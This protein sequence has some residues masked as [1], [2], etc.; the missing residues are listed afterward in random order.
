M[1]KVTTIESVRQALGQLEGIE[2]PD[3]DNEGDPIN[4]ESVYDYLDEDDQVKVDHALTTVRDYILDNGGDIDN[5]R[6]SEIKRNGYTI[7]MGPSQY[8]PMRNA[9][10]VEAGEWTLDLSDREPS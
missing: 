9:G 3:M 8:D 2:R 1:L 5:R 4:S 7:N 10:Y 6:V